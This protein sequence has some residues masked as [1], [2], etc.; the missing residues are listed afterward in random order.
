MDE[1]SEFEGGYWRTWV[2]SDSKVLDELDAES[3]KMRENSRVRI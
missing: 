1:N 3:K 2:L